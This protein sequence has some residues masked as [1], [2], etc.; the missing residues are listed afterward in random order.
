MNR[1]MILNMAAGACVLLPTT[2]L[3]A[4]TNDEPATIR[5]SH[6]VLRYDMVTLEDDDG[7]TTDKTEASGFTTFPS[8]IEIAAFAKGYAV[9]AYPVNQGFSVLA[10]K[11]IGTNQEAGLS[12]T[13]NTRNV[14]DGDETS[15]N[16]IGAYYFYSRALS[17][18][19]TFEFDINPAL[20]MDSEKSTSGG[21]TPTTQ[22][23]DGSG[24]SLYFDLL[25]VV[26]L[27]KNFEYVFGIDYNY[28]KV[29]TKVKSGG[30][31]NTEKSTDSGLG[32]I[33]AK[34]RYLI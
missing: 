8:G 29:E 13:L 16:S 30:T 15:N 20:I 24:Y 9:Y 12:A 32:L 22:E 17:P 1:K 5:L 2:F 21:P 26:P 7:T 31:S 3:R 18:K 6:G 11:A 28:R 4:E 25:G 34:F 10:G 23:A 14:K 33:L 19:V 27:A